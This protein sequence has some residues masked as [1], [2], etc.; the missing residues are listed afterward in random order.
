MCGF[1][2]VVGP[3]D[4]AFVGD[5]EPMAHTLRHRGPDDFGTWTQRFDGPGAGFAV[6][7][8]HTRLSILDLSPRGHQPMVAADGGAVVAYNGEIY[9]FAVLR[10]ELEGLGH[11]F[12]SGTDTE[13]LLA[14]WRAWGLEALE[15]FNGMFAF[16]LWDASQRK[17]LLA[18]DRLGIKPLYWRFTDG[19]LTFGS[20][21]RALRRHRAFRP[22]ID[23]AALGRFLRYGYVIGEPSIYRHTSRLRPGGWLLWSDGRVELG[24]Y[25]R[26]EDA[27]TEPVPASFDAAVDRLEALLCQAVERRLIADVPLGA[28][29][30]GGVDSSTVVALMQECA[31]GP[32]RTFSIG[33]RE[34][35]WDE[36][37]FARDV[38]KHLGTDH[39]ELY[40]GREEA[41]AVALELADLYDEPFADASAIPTVLLSRLTRQHVTVSLSGDGGDEL[42][43]GYDRYRNYDVLRRLLRLPGPLRRL[44]VGLAPL[45]PHSRIRN[46]LRHLRGGEPWSIAEDMRAT[47]DPTALAAACGAAGGCPSRAFE[48]MFRSAPGDD[49]VVRFMFGEAATYLPDD[50][51]TKLDRASMSVALEGRVPLLDHEVV[52]FA[53]GLPR[54]IFWHEGRTK[55]PLRA[56]LHR[57]VPRHLIDRP[58]H[59]FGIPLRD[60]LGADLEA[61]SRRYLDPRRLAEEG[62]LAAEGA[63]RLRESALRKE[64]PATTRLWH[65]LCFERWF[66]RTHRGEREA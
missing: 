46:G 6:G 44:L 22:E 47:F 37:P 14:A 54:E 32:V 23:P 2:G 12:G 64:G 17:L 15:R 20:E 40:V 10:E 51:L 34:R 30:S 21:L 36:A 24:R 62:L 56:V 26:L 58:K 18:R 9:N 5:V 27:R 7:L 42:F 19:V 29:L 33:F 13:V 43:G 39:T 11:A 49:D 66:A 28:F 16:A 50:I 57:R 41:R 48:A 63:A 55:A 38:A 35:G 25:W 8:G 61:W 45:V 53:L 52:G 59:G 31:P 65:L 4:R 60:L 3:E 1:C